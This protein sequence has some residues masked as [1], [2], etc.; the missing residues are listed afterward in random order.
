V[1][2]GRL[3]PITVF[4]VIANSVESTLER[5]SRAVKKGGEI[6]ALPRGD[7]WGPRIKLSRAI[8]QMSRDGVGRCLLA[9]K[10]IRMQLTRCF[11]R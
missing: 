6:I 9:I 10:T 8:P 1:R 7:K 4:A 5:L 2:Q 11:R 3:Y